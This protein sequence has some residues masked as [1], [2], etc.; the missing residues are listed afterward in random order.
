MG[1]LLLSV[2]MIEAT[3]IITVSGDSNLYSQANLKYYQTQYMKNFIVSG[4]AIVL[5]NTAS[6][7][8][9]A[10]IQPYFPENFSNLAQDIIGENDVLTYINIQNAVCNILVFPME[11]YQDLQNGYITQAQFNQILS[12]CEACLEQVKSFEASQLSIIQTENYTTLTKNGVDEFQLTDVISKKKYT[13]PV[14]I[15]NQQKMVLGLAQ[16]VLE[17]Q[18][19]SDF[20]DNLKACALQIEQNKAYY[21]SFKNAPALTLSGYSPS[22][23]TKN[24]SIDT[25]QAAS[26]LAIHFN[27]MQYSKM[28]K[29]VLISKDSKASG[30]TKALVNYDFNTNGSILGPPKIILNDDTMDLSGVP[31]MLYPLYGYCYSQLG[32]DIKSGYLTP[33]QSQYAT[34]CLNNS[35]IDY[36][37]FYIENSYFAQENG[38]EINMMAELGKNISFKYPLY[39]IQLSDGMTVSVAQIIS[40]GS[41]VNTLGALYRPMGLLSDTNALPSSLNAYNTIKLSAYTDDWFGPK[42][43]SYFIQSLEYQE[44]ITNYQP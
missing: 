5:N 13:Y 8:S 16:T 2:A 26:T 7:Y 31:S 37:N 24:C 32:K 43:L 12:N 30:I 25:S 34:A 19:S 29:R 22:W 28:P 41:G 20:M 40:T 21:V 39:F 10:A 36:V 11:A 33:E 18:N 38:L 9:K 3:P 27:F 23:I 44:Y 35:I 14:A 17:S 42:S 6:I 15:F 1:L 4:S